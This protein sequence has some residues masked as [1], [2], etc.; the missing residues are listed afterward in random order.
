M[1]FEFA[2]FPRSKQVAKQA[3]A[4]RVKLPEIHAHE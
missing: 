3:L 2:Q 4:A 1:G